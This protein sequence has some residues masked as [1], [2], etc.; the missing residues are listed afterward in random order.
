I[1]TAILETD[2]TKDES[3]QKYGIDIFMTM[4]AIRSGGHLANVN[5]DKKLHTPSFNKLEY[6]FPQ[7]AT[8]VLMSSIDEFPF[9]GPAD[10]GE[11]SNILPDLNFNHKEAAKEMFDR[12]QNTI[13]SIQFQ[14]LDGQ[15]LKDFRDV[16]ASNTEDQTKIINLWTDLL[17]EWFNYF[18]R[19]SLSRAEI[20]Q[21]GQELLPFF[22]LRATNFWFWA[23]TV[24]VA[25]VEKAIRQQAELLRN[26]FKAV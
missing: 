24:E 9:T 21:A 11:E 19:L 15:L 2:L 7:I 4:T 18:H 12:A 8:S 13:E 14:W 22:V 20:K 6:M 26:K 25:E 16:V 5:L 10:I 3:I 23:E 1:A 17:T